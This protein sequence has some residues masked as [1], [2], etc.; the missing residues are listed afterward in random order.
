MCVYVCIYI[1]GCGFVW[2]SYCKRVGMAM[3]RVGGRG[4]L[5]DGVFAPA[6]H[7]FV[8]PNP[9]PAS[10]DR[11]NFLTP[12]PP[13]GA[14]RSPALPCKTLLL[15]NLPTTITIVFNKTCFINKNILEIT[16]KFIPSN[17]TN[18]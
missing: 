12:S 6:P 7:D 17:Q 16:N 11:K 4:V 14:P 18:F 3:G 10:H 2:F 13:N 5:K 1:Y 9:H 8:L 15:V